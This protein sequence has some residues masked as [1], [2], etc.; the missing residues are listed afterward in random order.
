MQCEQVLYKFSGFDPEEHLVVAPEGLNRF[1][2]NG[3]GGEVVASWMTKRDRLEEIKDFSDYLTKLYQQH[4]DQLP[5]N[6]IKVMLG[7]SQGGTT[8]Y[9]WLNSQKAVCD[10]LIAYSC[11]IPEDINLKRSVTNLNDANQIFTYGKQDQFLT[12][13]RI[14]QIQEV[15]SG[16]FL[17][18][19]MEP[20]EGLHRID[21][22]QLVYLFDKYIKR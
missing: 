9:R 19:I 22:D 6:C 5:S 16:N 15:I 4:I 18:V 2:A 17:K 21:K 20:Y 14:E 10:H 8:L 7:F 11:W 3:F 1:Y 12:E 13:R